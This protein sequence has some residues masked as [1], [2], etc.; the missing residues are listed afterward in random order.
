MFCPLGKYHSF[1]KDVL[2]IVCVTTDEGV[3]ITAHV[4]LG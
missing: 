4:F 3:A 2:I 1:G